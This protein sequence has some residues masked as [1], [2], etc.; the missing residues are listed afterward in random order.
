MCAHQEETK[1]WLR[2]AFR[3]VH[4]HF[5]EIAAGY[6]DLRTTDLEPITH[7]VRRL[8]G[9]SHV[10]AAD[11]GCGAGRYDLKLFQHLGHKIDHLYCL[12]TTQGMLEQVRDYLTRHHIRDFQ[13]VR[14]DARNLPFA[15]EHLN[16]MF[17]F[18]AVHHFHVLGFL[19]EASRV[20]ERRGCLFIYTRLRS[21]NRRSIW[22]RYFPLFCEKETRLYES[23][24]LERMVSATPRL[25]MEQVQSFRYQ[26]VSTLKRLRELARHRHYSTFSLYSKSELEACLAQFEK[27]IRKHFEDV[28]NVRWADE[29]VMLTVRKD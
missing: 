20:L 28:D 18:N 3:S 13:V 25:R 2:A 16:C 9:I 19:S 1:D 29:N 10:K 24:E 17:T 12:D 21:Q 23:D 5:S 26:R 6:R 7:I 27:N 11:V 14:S 15:A 4:E 22:G 8:R